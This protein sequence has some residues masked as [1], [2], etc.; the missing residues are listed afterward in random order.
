MYGLR[1]SSA[2]WILEL[3]ETVPANPK[4]SICSLRKHRSPTH[5]PKPVQRYGTISSP[6][7]WKDHPQ[8]GKLSWQVRQCLA[9][10]NHPSDAKI[11]SS[12]L[13]EDIYIYIYPSLR[14]RHWIE[15]RDV[16]LPEKKRGRPARSK[17]P[18]TQRPTKHLKNHIREG[19]GMQKHPSAYVKFNGYP[20]SLAT[21]GCKLNLMSAR[22]QWRTAIAG[23]L[24]FFR[25]APQCRDQCK[26]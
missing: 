22:N 8:A 19:L 3:M 20:Y 7:G 10:G 5:C 1:I 15:S 16:A 13:P 18:W 9:S 26:S 2:Y 11:S 17:T 23:I 25:S 14:K 24:R 12:I 6:N 21:Q 4:S